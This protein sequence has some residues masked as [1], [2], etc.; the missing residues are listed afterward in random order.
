MTG[1]E[2]E[3]AAEV[4]VLTRKFMGAANRL[5]DATEGCARF[6]AGSLAHAKATTRRLKCDADYQRTYQALDVLID[7]IDGKGSL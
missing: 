1:R 3:L 5:I 4:A 7:E 2:I 6:A